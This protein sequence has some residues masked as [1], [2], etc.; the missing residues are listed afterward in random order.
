VIPPQEINLFVNP[1]F[2]K[3]LEGWKL[4]RNRG[5]GQM[6]IDPKESYR[7]KPVLRIDNAEPDD[8]HVLQSV[9]V[10]PHTRYKF[11]GY[12]KTGELGSAAEKGK[13]EACIAVNGGYIKTPVVPSKQ[14]WTR[15]TKEFETKEETEIKVGMRLGF[16][17]NLTSGTAW[18]ADLSLNEAAPPVQAAAPGP[19]SASTVVSAAGFTNSLGMKFVGVPGTKIVMCIH[20]TRKKDYA[21]YAAET[22]NVH[23]AW[24]FAHTG[25]K[26]NGD[27]PVGR[28]DDDPVV[29]VS[30][31]DATA[32]CQ[33]LTK[34]DGRVCRLPTDHE[35]SMAV[36]IGQRE[37]Q[38]LT[39]EALN[40]KINN[41][42]P[43]GIQWPPP[44]G[45]GN[46]NIKDHDDGY[47]TTAPVMS[48]NPN[49]L[50][51]YDMAG[52][53]WEWCEDWFNA[54][55]KERVIRGASWA[56]NYQANFLSSRRFHHTPET[57]SNSCGFRC[58][59]VLP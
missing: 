21:A 44:K 27:K 16:Y 3:G 43:W 54:D 29:S 55:Q 46:F 34:K 7:G 33:W 6:S 42:Y 11:A 9:A 28:N 10:K 18:F 53:A 1:S 15:V 8:T 23:R 13:P 14:D 47:E 5:V 50:G 4:E 25:D 30:W 57:R 39:P 35:W 19:V 51:I 20:E 40:Q 59:I 58:V 45:A 41:E 48:F 26:N 31:E 17:S 56:D 22:P 38:S 52:N 12:I 32:F 24:L 37:S 49:R 36:G 2:E